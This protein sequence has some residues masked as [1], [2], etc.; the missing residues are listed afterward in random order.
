MT[1]SI[2]KL[3]AELLQINNS[4]K[5]NKHI[6]VANKD[7]LDKH[8]F[9]FSD[10]DKKSENG[11]KRDKQKFNDLKNPTNLPDSVNF[12]R[13]KDETDS[14]H[15]QIR[16]RHLMLNAINSDSSIKIKG[17]KKDV[18]NSNGHASRGYQAYFCGHIRNY[19]VDKNQ[20]HK[21]GNGG[22]YCHERLCPI[23]AKIKAFKARIK[24]RTMLEYLNKHYRYENG[25]PKYSIIFLTLS[26][27]NAK[28]TPK[29]FKRVHKLLNRNFRRMLKYK[30]FDGF[31]TDKK[32]KTRKGIVQGAIGKI[33]QTYN[34]VHD[35]WNL[36]LHSLLIVHRS[37]FTSK[38]YVKFK[39]WLASWEQACDWDYKKQGKHLQ[40]CVEKPFY[41]DKNGERHTLNEKSSAKER[42]KARKSEVDEETAYETKSIDFDKILRTNDHLSRDQRKKQQQKTFNTAYFGLKHQRTYNFIGLFRKLNRLYKNGSLDKYKPK[43]DHT[44]KYSWHTIYNVNTGYYDTDLFET[45]DDAGEARDAREAGLKTVLGTAEKLALLKNVRDDDFLKDYSFVGNGVIG[46]DSLDELQPDFDIHDA[47]EVID[48]LHNGCYFKKVHSVY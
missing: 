41:K 11:K 21:R 45:L 36:H 33:E 14:K 35:T 8:G 31:S 7:T 3:N 39:K 38:Y 1:V 48:A 2:K 46:N 20:K 5:F 30:R 10:Y 16:L 19:I 4:N 26:V 15:R 28:N 47:N 18:Y 23:C 17:I 13:L 37:Y 42:Q 43:D 12:G 29:D 25:N 24:V 9:R 32:G 6:P 34:V 44:Y 40:V 22:L 27:P